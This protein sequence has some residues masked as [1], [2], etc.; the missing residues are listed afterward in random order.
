MKT[1]RRF[2]AGILFLVPVLGSCDHP[3]APPSRPA[4]RDPAV[5]IQARVGAEFAIEIPYNP[6]V[7]PAYRH[8]LRRPLP[9]WLVDFGLD[10]SSD[11]GADRKPG[12]GGTRIYRFKAVRAGGGTI[13][14]AP[15]GKG[16]EPG[17]PDP[18]TFTVTVAVP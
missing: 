6:T 15:G 18:L 11:A 7:A 2:G 13:V 4:Y 9:D 16:D 17:R 8:E 1:I 5:P 10:G 3:A 14:F 12:S